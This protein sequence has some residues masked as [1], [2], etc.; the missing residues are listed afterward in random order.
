MPG[1]GAPVGPIYTTPMPA[2]DA[3]AP[4]PVGTATHTCT[5]P[6]CARYHLATNDP[7]CGACG[8]ATVVAKTV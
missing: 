2:K 5:N 3:H 8:N 1:Q 4:A 7:F 6:G